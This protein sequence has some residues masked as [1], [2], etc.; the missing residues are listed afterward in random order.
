MSKEMGGPSP[1]EMGI[2]ITPQESL[3]FPKTQESG[4]DEINDL[5]PAPPHTEATPEEWAEYNK[6]TEEWRQRQQQKKG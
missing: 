6:K 3:N 2:K 5:P 4:T 1:E